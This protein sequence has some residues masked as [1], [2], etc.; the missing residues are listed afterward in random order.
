MSRQSADVQAYLD[1]TVALQ[2]VIARDPAANTVW[3]PFSVASALALVTRGAAGTTK[4]EL[5]SLLLG[6]KSAEV[7]DL[8]RLLDKAERLAEP[9]G[10][11]QPPVLEVAN[12]LW[13][14]RRISIKQTFAA[15]LRD[16]PSGSVRTA[17]FRD[18]PEGARNQ[19]NSDVAKTT[20]DL[21]PELLP[22]GVIKNDTVAALVNAL[23]LKVAWRHKFEDAAT[24]SRPF[25]AP[26]GVVQVPTMWLSENL[27][28]AKASGWQVVA[29][30][31]IGGV[32]AVVLLPDG[33]RLP[34]IDATT[35]KTLLDK[36]KR[37]KVSLRMPKLRLKLSAELTD[38]LNQLGVRTAFTDD[39][40]FSGVSDDPLAIQAVIHESVLK[41][42]EQGL[43]G[44][45]ATAVM[46]RAL[47]LDMSKPVEVT[48][49]RPFLLLVRHKD[50][51]VV[52]FSARV[53]DPAKKD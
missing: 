10:D 7:E 30:P 4:D 20:R 19:I 33:A 18:D 21:I 39:A 8:I 34:S 44:A 52:Y 50:S 24:E 17:P 6:D 32:E 49:D 36:P 45:A 31:A 29:L 46:M 22:E 48:V 2:D 13:A 35:L 1:F 27:G 42:D 5:V 43:E 12:T 40:D 47:S 28:Y 41:L 11:Q 25:H 15:A 23:Y 9:H 51:G 3:S 16:M 38:A 14:D 26:G 37:Q 53:N